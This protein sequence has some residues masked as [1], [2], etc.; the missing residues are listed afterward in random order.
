MDERAFKKIITRARELHD[1]GDESRAKVLL[2][3]TSAQ[4]QS[5]FRKGYEDSQYFNRT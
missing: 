5:D 3:N 4:L 1:G 2:A